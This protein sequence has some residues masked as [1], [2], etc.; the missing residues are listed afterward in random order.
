[1]CSYCYFM[2]FCMNS[3]KRVQ[4]FRKII[5]VKVILQRLTAVLKVDCCTA[6]LLSKKVT[7]ICKK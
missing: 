4:Y 2:K 3:F 5:N 1:M 6:K 7:A